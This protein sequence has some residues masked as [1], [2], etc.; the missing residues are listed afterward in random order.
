M[1][2]MTASEPCHCNLLRKV[3]R[4]ISAI[5]DE[6]LA[7]SGLRITQYA[8]LTEIQRSGPVSITDLAAIMV[9]ERNGLGHTL[10]LLE[11]DGLV[12][13][14]TGKDRRSRTVS[15]TELGQRR[16]ADLRPCWQRAQRRVEATGLMSAI[17]QPLASFVAG[18]ITAS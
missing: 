8:L 3:A 16:L 9:M 5:Y 4:R 2:S 6:E 13:S 18:E 1:T 11:R 14:V 7:A 10:R 12:V 17:R 15:L